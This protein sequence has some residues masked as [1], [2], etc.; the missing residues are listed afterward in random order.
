MGYSVLT[1]AKLYHLVKLYGVIACYSYRHLVN[2]GGC[3]QIS[4]GEIRLSTEISRLQATCE[5]LRSSC[6]N[7]EMGA[8]VVSSDGSELLNN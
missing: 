2:E 1:C 4:D 6:S 8:K 7:K 5:D 3:P